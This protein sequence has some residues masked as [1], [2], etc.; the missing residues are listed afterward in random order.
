MHGAVGARPQDSNLQPAVCRWAAGRAPPLSSSLT[1]T[2]LTLTQTN[3]STR[4]REHT[5]TASARCLRCLW[6]C[7][8]IRP[9]VRESPDR[10]RCSS[11]SLSLSLL[12][13]LFVLYSFCGCGEV[14]HASKIC[15]Y[16][17]LW[18]HLSTH[19]HTHSLS[20]P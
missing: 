1:S 13:L 7:I 15:I 11:L 4:A 12:A 20:N 17:R 2:T 5:L 19:T 14:S 10:C 9:S 3:K 16:S 18:G 8:W 6:C